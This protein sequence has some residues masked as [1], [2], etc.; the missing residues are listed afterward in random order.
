MIESKKY[1]HSFFVRMS[2]NIVKHMHQNWIREFV[3][4]NFNAI[5]IIFEGK[6]QFG[7]VDSV[8][9]SEN[10]SNFGKELNELQLT[11]WKFFLTGTVVDGLRKVE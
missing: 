11:Y 4:A 2:D 1:E 7:N 9:L 5:N 10:N 3:N 8:P 6:E